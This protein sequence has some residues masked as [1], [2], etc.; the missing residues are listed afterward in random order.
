MTSLHVF[1]WPPRCPMATSHSLEAASV[2]DFVEKELYSAM[3]EAGDHVLSCT[4]PRMS[5][6]T[7]RISVC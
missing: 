4:N 7:L 2:K 1:I 5:Q 6:E 3:K